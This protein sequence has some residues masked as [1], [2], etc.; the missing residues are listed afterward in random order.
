LG[1]LPQIPNLQTIPLSKSNTEAYESFTKKNSDQFKKML[2]HLIK[3]IWEDSNFAEDSLKSFNQLA[4]QGVKFA[5]NSPSTSDLSDQNTPKQQFKTLLKDYFGDEDECRESYP[6]LHAVLYN[7]Q[8]DAPSWSEFRNAVLVGLNPNQS[9]EKYYETRFPVLLNADSQIQHSEDTG[10]KIG[11]LFNPEVTMD[12]LDILKEKFS[13]DLSHLYQLNSNPPKSLIDL[14]YPDGED[15]SEIYDFL[16]QL[17][18]IEINQPLT[19]WKM[20]SHSPNHQWDVCDVDANLAWLE[21][22]FDIL[23]GSVTGFDYSFVSSADEISEERSIQYSSRSPS[24][25]YH[26]DDKKLDIRMPEKKS[27]LSLSEHEYLWRVLRK[28]VPSL[29]GFT[30]KRLLDLLHDKLGPWCWSKRE[31]NQRKDEFILQYCQGDLKEIR[32]YCEQRVNSAPDEIDSA[33]ADISHLYA[34]SNSLLK[35]SKSVLKELYNQHRSS[36]CTK[37]VSPKD[38]LDRY[39]SLTRKHNMQFDKKLSK[40]SQ[41]LE[42]LGDFILC[43]A[44]EQNFL[45]R[46]DNFN[47][48]GEVF[49]LVDDYRV[50]IRNALIETA[51]VAVDEKW[52]KMKL[53]CDVRNDDELIEVRLHKVHALFIL[54]YTSW[55]VESDC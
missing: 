26:A 52:V 42:T 16:N 8:N 19:P 12:G 15:G 51:N 39:V 25:F 14:N 4:K 10:P 28:R 3:Q 54:G 38:M 46:S 2:F 35:D 30:E 34:S 7:V 20:L 31:G 6:Y 22:V 5:N 33:I 17:A 48:V 45:M 47:G 13:N 11:D 40:P 41:E 53:F 43:N 44:N 27:Q 23:K 18:D 9:L 1:G 24:F 49:T 29:L 32:H 21:V 55:G 37:F 50:V 36:I